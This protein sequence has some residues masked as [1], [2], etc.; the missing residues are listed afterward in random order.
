MK[1]LLQLLDNHELAEYL[2]D[3]DEFVEKAREAFKENNIEIDDKDLA[4][5]AKEIEENLCKKRDLLDKDLSEDKNLMQDDQLDDVVGGFGQPWSK[6][7]KAIGVLVIAA[8]VAA[9]GGLAGSVMGVE[10]SA[11]KKKSLKKGAAIGAGIGVASGAAIGGAVGSVI[12]NILDGLKG[13]G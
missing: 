12:V 3:N 4:Y 10:S 13:L 11:K 8:S 6:K 2:M 1:K 9:I 5:L 7:E